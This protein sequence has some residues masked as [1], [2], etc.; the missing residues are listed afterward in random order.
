MFCP[1]CGNKIDASKPFCP[2]CGEKIKIE[3]RTNNTIVEPEYRYEYHPSTLNGFSIT[4]LVIGSISIVL[5]IILLIL[6]C[7]T[8]INSISFADVI[9]FI[10]LGLT[11]G[12]LSISG[13]ITSIVGM[14][15]KKDVFGIMG[16]VLSAF[17]IIID[18]IAVIVFITSE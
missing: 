14:A 4:G 8:N 6:V 9:V 16:I 2:D 11:S 1:K 18:F 17:T 7:N 10:V 15:K 5:S 12:I 13:L 3:E